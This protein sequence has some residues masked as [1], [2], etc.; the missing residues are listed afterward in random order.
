MRLG[1]NHAA[2]CHSEAII[3]DV[4]G[5]AVNTLRKHFAHELAVDV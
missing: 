2:L 3:A 4:L 5:I 1:M